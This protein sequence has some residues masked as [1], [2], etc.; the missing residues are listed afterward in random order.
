MLAPMARVPAHYQEEPGASRCGDTFEEGLTVTGEIYGRGGFG[1]DHIKF[2]PRVTEE[3][4]GTWWS[5]DSADERD[6]I[7]DVER[8]AERVDDQLGQ[9]SGELTVEQSNSVWRLLQL[10]EDNL[11]EVDELYA[12]WSGEGPRPGLD[13]WRPGAGTP[14]EWPLESGDRIFDY[15]GECYGLSGEWVDR[16]AYDVASGQYRPTGEQYWCP[17]QDDRDQRAEDRERIH[18]LLVDAARAV[19]CAQW[20]LWRMVLYGRAV[21]D[22]DDKYGGQL[23]MVLQ[24]EAPP[25][26]VFEFEPWQSDEPIDVWPVWPDPV[27]PTPVWPVWPDEEPPPDDGLGG[28]GVWEPPDEPGAM[29]EDDV[30]AEPPP[31]E[32]PSERPSW[33]APLLIGGAA[34]AAAVILTR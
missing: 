26:P 27:E 32:E 12:Y 11:E 24:T 28:A 19:R 6:F 15:R 21:K 23:G 2:I 14:S 3:P 25:P 1:A 10:A 4:G 18:Q 20:G 13:L 9:L 17:D 30:P 5:T 16:H 29:P 33:A 22:W 34:L 7:G 31:P 8:A